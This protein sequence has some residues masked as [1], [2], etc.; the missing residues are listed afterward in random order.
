MGGGGGGVAMCDL[1]TLL[2]G[3]T[4]CLNDN[5]EVGFCILTKAE[6]LLV[7]WL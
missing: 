6:R 5:S 4:N 2:S 1:Q 7:D 3:S